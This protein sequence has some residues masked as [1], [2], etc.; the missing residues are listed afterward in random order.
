MMIDDEE[1]EEVVEEEEEEKKTSSHLSIKEEG[2]S[3][4]HPFLT[5]LFGC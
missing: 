5:Q 2:I 1:K 4:R 3:V